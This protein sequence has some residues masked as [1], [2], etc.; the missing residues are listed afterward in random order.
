MER[1]RRNYRGRDTIP[2][3][4]MGPS[5]SEG[6]SS[7]R[8]RRLFFT[9]RG[10]DPL[11]LLPLLL[12]LGNYLLHAGVLTRHSDTRLYVCSITWGRPPFP[13]CT[14]QPSVSLFRARRVTRVVSFA[15]LEYDW[16]GGGREGAGMERGERT[17]RNE[18]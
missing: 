1:H 18:G 17:S 4:W 2:L 12:L 10:H 14:L 9:A 11:L 15:T 7:N 6:T 3:T 16:G 8:L 13:P 5:A